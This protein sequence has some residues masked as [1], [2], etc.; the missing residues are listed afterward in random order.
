MAKSQTVLMLHI[1]A[2][3]A[4]AITLLF[5]GAAAADRYNL[6]LIHGWA[7]AHGAIFIVLPAYFLLS[8]FALWPIARRFQ[9][10]SASASPHQS[11]SFLAVAS[12]LLSGGGFLIPLLGSL[13]GIASG[14]LARR[15]CKGNPQLT[16]SGIALAGLILGYLGLA[17]S[18]YIVAMVSWAAS[19]HGS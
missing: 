1:G 19:H 13:L 9:S 2:A 10:V 11:V 6:P 4:V 18:V 8:Y 3:S 16:G 12:L 5:V 17:Y 7:L 14:H 15:R